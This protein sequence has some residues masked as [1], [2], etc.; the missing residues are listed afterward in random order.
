M[1]VGEVESRRSAHLTPHIHTHTPHTHTHPTH[2]HTPHTHPH[3]H[4]THTPTQ[5]HTHTH[6]PHTHTPHTHTHTPH[7]HHT[8]TGV[9]RAEARGRSNA[10]QYGDYVEAGLAQR[11]AAVLGVFNLVL[12]WG[13]VSDRFWKGACMMYERVCVCVCVS[14]SVCVCDVLRL[15][16]GHPL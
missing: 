15:S 4:P 3:T 2:P 6:T 1:R 16:P 5:T 14:V 9:V 10:Q 7:T 8:H 12:G 11:R 13:P